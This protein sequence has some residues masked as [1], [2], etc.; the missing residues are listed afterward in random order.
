MQ[1]DWGRQTVALA[2][3]YASFPWTAG[4]ENR[5]HG[6]DEQGYR[7]DTP[8][9]GY[10]VSQYPCAWWRV[11]G[12]NR[13]MPYC[14]GGWSTQTQFLDGLAHGKYAGNVPDGRP[15]YISHACVG[16]DCSGL[17]SVCWHLPK[18]L[19]T[20]DFAPLCDAV[21]PQDMLAGDIL[22]YP[23]RHVI[24]FDDYGENGCIHV[25]ES[26]R[27]AGRVVCRSRVLSDLLAEGYQ[28]FRLQPEHRR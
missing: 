2:K 27:Y 23:G 24:L 1:N 4:A 22:L 17:V 21:S 15:G 13:G 8:D 11:D 9:E 5:F 20:R 25:V 14:W 3:E 26:T 10:T 28:A 16:M 7:V 19:S 6:E 18:K 12:E